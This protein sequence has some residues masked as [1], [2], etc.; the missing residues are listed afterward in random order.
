M[1]KQF[2]EDPMPFEEKAIHNVGIKN[3]GLGFRVFRASA[4][5]F[6]LLEDD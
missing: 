2:Q 4:L 6:T 1:T 5:G 3:S